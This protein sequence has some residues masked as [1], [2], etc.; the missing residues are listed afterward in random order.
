MPAHHWSKCCADPL[1]R[2]D[3]LGPE[4]LEDVAAVV[5]PA[6]ANDD[7]R[8][9]RWRPEPMWQDPLV[10]EIR[11]HREEYAARFNYDIRALCREAREPQKNSQRRTVSRPPKRVTL[12]TAKP[13]QPAA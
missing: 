9:K 12:A 4:A 2:E 6:P 3:V 1:C 7:V 13:A 10:E 8:N 11:R 5:E